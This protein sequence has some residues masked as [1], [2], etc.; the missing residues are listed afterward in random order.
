MGDTIVFR[1]NGNSKFHVII[2]DELG[3]ENALSVIVDPFPARVHE[4]HT[5]ATE[6]VNRSNIQ[7]QSG[8]VKSPAESMNTSHVLPQPMEM[9]RSTRRLNGPPMESSPTK[10]QRHIQMD[11]S[12]QGNM[13]PINILSSES[14]ES[15]SSEDGCG[16]HDVSASNYNARKN[17]LTSSRR[18]QLK[19]GYIT[20]S[21][22]KLTPAEQQKVKEKVQSRQSEIPIVVAVMSK[23]NVDSGCSLNFPSHYAMKYLGGD[24]NMY[25]Q[26]LGQKLCCMARPLIIEGL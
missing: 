1:Y 23:S 15:F 14:S 3:R 25:L 6:T 26:V 4:R 7:P 11:K 8:Q 18:G 21:K 5:N 16:V 12:S 20:T 22:T 2:F 17:R 24:P 10:R 19:D 9:Q 13:A